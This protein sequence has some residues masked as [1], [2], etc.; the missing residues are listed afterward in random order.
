MTPFFKALDAKTSDPVTWVH[1]IVAVAASLLLLGLGIGFGTTHK[2]AAPL[3][4]VLAALAGALAL[5]QFLI[6]HWSEA[7]EHAA[8]RQGETELAIVSAKNQK[9]HNASA[10]VWYVALAALVSLTGV[11]AGAAL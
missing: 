1:F 6:S 7:S 9:M 2:E 8:A 11:A 10:W 3:A 5:P 4:G